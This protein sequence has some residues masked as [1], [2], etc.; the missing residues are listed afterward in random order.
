MS[1]TWAVGKARAAGAGTEGAERAKLGE[2][3][4]GP[5]DLP[6]RTLQDWEQAGD[7][8]DTCIF[9]KGGRKKRT[10]DRGAR[11]RK[12]R[13]ERSEVP[14]P[15]PACTRSQVRA[16]PLVR[17]LARKKV[18]G[19]L[20]NLARGSRACQGTLRAHTL[21]LFTP[22]TQ[23]GFKRRNHFLEHQGPGHCP[24]PHFLAV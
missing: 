18:P 17:G 9:G 22:K 15:H 10:V 2:T 11:G 13:K 23:S 3:G 8:I 7:S 4:R 14:S 21:L 12:G 1:H 20:G 24:P 16:T 5:S 6:E 19:Q